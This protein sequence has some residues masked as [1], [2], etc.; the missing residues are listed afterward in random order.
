MRGHASI[1][2]SERLEDTQRTTWGLYCA[3]Y[4][5]RATRDVKSVCR[6]AL[7]MS[8]AQRNVQNQR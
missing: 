6:A 2:D 7:W 3:V 1:N 8:V 4:K 5:C